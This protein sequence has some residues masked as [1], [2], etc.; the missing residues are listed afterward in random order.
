MIATKFLLAASVGV[1]ATALASNVVAA[2]AQPS[3]PAPSLPGGCAVSQMT[4]AN[5]AYCERFAY[6]ANVDD[7]SFGVAGDAYNALASVHVAL[8]QSPSRYS[9][10]IFLAYNRAA[11]GRLPEARAALA[12]AALMLSELE[13]AP[14]ADKGS[15]AAELRILRASLVLGQAIEIGH[16]ADGAQPADR[17]KWFGEAADRAAE[18]VR[19]ASESSVIQSGAAAG[20]VEAQSDTIHIAPVDAEALNANRSAA[21]LGAFVARRPTVEERLLTLK[22]HAE[23]VGAAASLAR[24][25]LTSART[26]NAAATRDL[27]NL[28]PALVSWLR[29]L[30]SEQSAALNLGAGAP[31]DVEKRISE[32]LR[33]F[34]GG[35]VIKDEQRSRLEAY[36]LR[37][38]AKSQADHGDEAGAQAN[39]QRSFVILT[40]QSDGRLPTRKDLDLYLGILAK[41]A[42]NGDTGAADQ[43]FS[44]ASVATETRTAQTLAELARA[45]E[46]NDPEVTAAY[47]DLQEARADLQRA[48]DQLADLQSRKDAP[49]PES[50][51]ARTELDVR[52]RAIREA[53]LTDAIGQAKTEQL[54]AQ[55][56]FER[57]QKAFAVVAKDKMSLFTA[58]VMDVAGLQSRLGPGEAYVRFLFLEKGVGYGIIV[59]KDSPHPSIWQLKVSTAIIEG[60]VL[61]FR[62]FAK[63]GQPPRK[64]GEL[65]DVSLDKASSVYEDLFHGAELELARSDSLVIEPSGKL[66][67]LPFGALATSAPTESLTAAAK[68][69]DFTQVPWLGRD[70][71]IEISVGAATFVRLRGA[72]AS[73]AKREI[74]AYADPVPEFASKAEVAS[75][76][77]N[78]M[79][80]ASRTPGLGE[81][82]EASLTPEFRKCHSEASDLLS[83]E[84]LK[85][86][87]A[88]AR[89]AINSLGGRDADLVPDAQFTDTAVLARDAL[90]QTS[91]DRLENYKVLL[92]STH[93]VLPRLSECWPNPLLVTSRDAADPKSLGYLDTAVIGRLHLDANLAVLSACDTARGGDGSESFGGLAMSFIQAHS[94]G[95]LVSQWP[96]SD[97]TTVLMD[98]FFKSLGQGAKPRDALMDAERSLMKGHGEDG[99]VDD[100]SLSHPYFWAAFTVVGGVATK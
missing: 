91:D 2:T 47:R 50:T 72:K 29:S 81:G 54:K 19:I 41:A 3:N 1:L 71:A 23:F 18:A 93:A 89:H 4:T 74:I 7:W 56:R 25:D 82:D 45:F 60:D 20:N 68:N 75:A 94:R 84:R 55:D 37:A 43:L 27:D 86:T 6:Q 57:A 92:F 21:N 64:P 49:S 44:V 46:S 79:I 8:G 61:E 34:H 28:N 14:G 76:R 69:F 63:L 53:A 30:T 96:V 80:A 83:F 66:Y 12:N 36:L 73:A 35:T 65:S 98:K 62:R 85:T 13:K 9:A 48:N 15:A 5:L 32:T 77:A 51:S 95:V 58:P 100:V 33:R 59:R 16:V 87:P 10:A 39:L 78:A 40:N 52:L 99:A 17:D 11:E 88:E 31:A 24:N 70:K 22:A 26:L 42:L 90:P 38:L 67:G 97:K